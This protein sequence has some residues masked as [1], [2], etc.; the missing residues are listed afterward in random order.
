MEAGRRVVFAGTQVGS[1]GV[2]APSAAIVP[3]S[4]ALQLLYRPSVA[5]RVLEEA[6]A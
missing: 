2:G 6:E 1:E 3:R 5:V 4:R